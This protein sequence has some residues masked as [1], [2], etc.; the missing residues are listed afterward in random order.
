MWYVLQVAEGRE[1]SICENCKKAFVGK[2]ASQIFVPKYVWLKKVKGVRKKE[3][4]PLFLGY[5]FAESKT[6]DALQKRLQLLQNVRPVCI[7]GGF[8][9][10]KEE[11]EVFLRQFLG[12]EKIV[13]FST[14]Y[15][16]DGEL[17]VIDGALKNFSKK[18][19]RIDR[20][21]RLAEMEIS[22]FGQER[23]IRVGL[24][25]KAKI[26]AREYEQMV[27]EA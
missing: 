24:E 2:E 26:A 10:I 19:R 18:I 15:I 9:P 23:R 6:P 8:Y 7:G 12:E 5:L 11:E 17:R 22:L 25:V 4:K 3:V 20:H 27:K 1:D 14:G 13:R 21:N 16:V